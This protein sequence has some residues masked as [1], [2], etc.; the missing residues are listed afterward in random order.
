MPHAPDD[1]AGPSGTER[2]DGSQAPTLHYWRAGEAR[3]LRWNLLFI[4]VAVTVVASPVIM[5]LSLAGTIAFEPEHGERVIFPVVFPYGYCLDRLGTAL[6]TG[7]GDAGGTAS[8]WIQLL[9]YGHLLGIGAMLGR[10]LRVAVVLVILHVAA[11]VLYFW[12]IEAIF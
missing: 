9:L 3:A 1:P 4:H 2:R 8:G 11:V 10:R 6:A 7:F 12:G 5:G